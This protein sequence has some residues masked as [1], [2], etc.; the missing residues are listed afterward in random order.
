MEAE[1]KTARARAPCPQQ[2]VTG[3]DGEP[4]TFYPYTLEKFAADPTGPHQPR[5]HGQG[6]RRPRIRAALFA[7]N[8]DRTAYGMPNVAPLN[9]TWADAMGANQV[10]YGAGKWAG[11]AIQLECG[12]YEQSASTCASSRRASRDSATRT[13]RC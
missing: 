10:T 5:L 8:G 7:L 3:P 11:S 12:L 4:L 13:S 2:T 1:A 9:C 6:R